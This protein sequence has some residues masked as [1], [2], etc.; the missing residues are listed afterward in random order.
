MTKGFFSCIILSFNLAHVCASLS[1]FVCVC[2]CV[3]VVPRVCFIKQ[4]SECAAGC[5]IVML[6]TQRQ[7]AFF[8]QTSGRGN[9]NEH[10]H[11][12]TTTHTH[13]HQPTIYPHTHTEV[14]CMSLSNYFI[15][16]IISLLPH[17]RGVIL[18]SVC[19]Y[20][21]LFPAKSLWESRREHNVYSGI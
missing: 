8:R 18:A 9:S 20:K 13:A 12:R 21:K 5:S 7:S 1:L 16:P 17:T 11:P 15:I 10:T 14:L 19:F 6:A 3:F 4:I 2:V